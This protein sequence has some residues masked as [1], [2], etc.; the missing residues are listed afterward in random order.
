MNQTAIV[1]A[2][3][4]IIFAFSS[5]DSSISP[6]VRE[7]G[8]FFGVEMDRVLLLIPGCPVGI[9]LG[10]FVG[11]ALTASYP[12]F[13]LLTLGS[14]GLFVSLALF[15]C[16]GQFETALTLRFIFG[17]SSGLTASCMWWLAFQGVDKSHYQAMVSVLMSARPLA[18][19]IGVPLA[20]IVAARSAWS[21]PFWGLAVLVAVSGAVLVVALSAMTE[22]PKVPFSPRRIV[23]DYWAAFEEPFALSYYAG[24]TIN[25][26]CYFGFYSMAGLWFI[27]QFGL[28]LSWI[29]TAL[30]LI[31]LGEAPV[32]F[33][34]PWLVRRLGHGPVFAASLAISAVVFPL[35]ISATFPLG[36]TIALITLFMV[37]DRIYITALVITIPA[38]FPGARNKTV[39]GSLNTL[40]AWGGLTAISWLEGQYL[41][42]AG[43]VLFGHLL[44]GCFVVGS[45]LLYRVQRATVLGR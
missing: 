37:L 40:T 30:F 3:F 24:L 25:R 22:P 33:V 7:L 16:T 5:V 41:E 43:L 11:P 17:L 35:F 32:S 44:T 15:L 38:M 18:T 31:G 21:V 20:G 23:G 13:W 10:V 34:V 36:V 45:L 42:T 19:A 6:M 4:F 39:F 12:V 27:R 26:M 9:V 1:V 8:A 29:S 14:L 2:S 28:T